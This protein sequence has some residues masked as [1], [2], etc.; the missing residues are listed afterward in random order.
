MRLRLTS[1][2]SDNVEPMIAQDQALLARGVALFND[3]E[4]FACHEVWEELWKSRT[5]EE[6]AALHGLIQAAAA[7]LHAERGNYR[8]ALSVC[9]KAMGNLESASDDCLGLRLKDFR[10]AL[11]AFFAGISL[12]QGRCTLSKIRLECL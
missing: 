2:A 3:G 5:G 11:S 10:L 4:Y 6:R 1:I 12:A 7:I 9:R 8:G